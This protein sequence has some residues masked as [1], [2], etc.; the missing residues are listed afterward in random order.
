MSNSPSPPTDAAPPRRAKKR[1]Y[2]PLILLVLLLAAAGVFYVR[3]VW[4]DAVEKN[5]ANAEAGT[6]TQLLQKPN[7]NVVV[8]CAIIVDAPPKDVYAVVT[9]YESHCMF[10]PYLGEVKATRQ[11]DGRIL[12]EGIAQSRLWGDWPFQSVVTHQESPDD[13]EYSTHWGEEDK[14]AFKV[15]RGGWNLTPVGPKKQQ[16]LLVFT[17]QIEMKDHSNAIVRNIIMDRQHAV[18]KA[19]RDETLKRKKT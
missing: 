2:I 10:L 16:T 11:S 7:G 13:G 15:N 14:G 12:L 3:G 5:P 18:V 8:R 19:M 17:L 9:D 6:V 4:A 1:V